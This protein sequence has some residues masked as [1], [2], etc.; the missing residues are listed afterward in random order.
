MYKS[1]S[2]SRGRGS[3]ERVEILDGCRK[4]RWLLVAGVPHKPLDESMYS[5][6]IKK[7][8]WRN[9]RDWLPIQ[10]VRFRDTFNLIAWILDL[11]PETHGGVWHPNVWWR[12]DFRV[13]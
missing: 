12:S 10:W 8:L 11:T 3:E 5:V 1:P 6:C 9:D 2:F 4:R 7:R 13:C